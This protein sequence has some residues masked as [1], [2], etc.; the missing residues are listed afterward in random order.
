[1]DNV[2]ITPN[3]FLFFLPV[4]KSNGLLYVKGWK[5]FN[6]LILDKFAISETIGLD[7]LH[8]RFKHWK[9]TSLTFYYTYI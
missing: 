4:V 6:N 7:F 2:N 5:I 3:S 1:M 9:A 8:L